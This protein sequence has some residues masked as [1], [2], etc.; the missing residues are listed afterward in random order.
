MHGVTCSI[1]STKYRGRPASSWRRPPPFSRQN[2]QFPDL[3]ADVPVGLNQLDEIRRRI[4]IRCSWRADLI[5]H[6]LP[7][8]DHAQIVVA[9]VDDFHRR[10][11]LGTG[12]QFWIF[13]WILP[14]GHA[15]ERPYPGTPASPHCGRQNRTHGSPAAGL[16]QRRGF[17]QA[18]MLGREHL[19]LAH[20]R[21]HI[22]IAP[23]TGT[24]SLSPA[25]AYPA[26]IAVPVHRPC[27]SAIH[28][29]A[30]TSASSAAWGLVGARHCCK[31]VQHFLRVPS[32]P[33]PTMGIS[34]ATVLDI[35]AGSHRYG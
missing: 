12:G 14:H 26:I 4:L 9:Q 35:E 18:I 8:L 33:G 29:S 2:P 13:I 19:V 10:V 25:G 6:V 16:I 31:L 34:A 23:V 15:G 30:S 3:H 11:V 22:G 21:S 1:G 24:N 27:L 17:G 28:R 7:L 32:V 20:V 5:L